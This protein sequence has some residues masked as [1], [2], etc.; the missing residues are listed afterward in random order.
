MKKLTDANLSP[1]ALMGFWASY[2]F[3]SGD[4]TFK[5]RAPLSAQ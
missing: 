5:M 4:T 3:A 2:P 1:L